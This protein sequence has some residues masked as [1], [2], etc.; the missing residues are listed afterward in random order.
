[1]LINLPKAIA[2]TSPTNQMIQEKKRV[3]LGQK[4]RGSRSSLTEY[5][6]D[7]AG[8]INKALLSLVLLSFQY[9]NP[10]HAEEY[11]LCDIAWIVLNVPSLVS[12][13]RPK[14]SQEFC[15]SGPQFPLEAS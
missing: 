3:I 4:S 8:N 6:E 7:Q 11:L 12:L 1:M 9:S 5:A 2:P 15:T 14:V 10:K 13:G